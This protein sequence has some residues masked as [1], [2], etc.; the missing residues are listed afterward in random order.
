MEESP[1]G[2]VPA[3]F[4]FSRRH[5]RQR[6]PVDCASSG[7]GRWGSSAHQQPPSGWQVMG[8]LHF[9]Q[10]VC[11]WKVWREGR[12]TSRSLGE[13][14]SRS[15]MDEQLRGLFPLPGDAMAASLPYKTACTQIRL[16]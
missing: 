16:R 9:T 7:R 15:Q 6:Q 12:H 14:L 13:S 5:A 8:A 3:A 4:I 2:A 10:R 1:E 11:M